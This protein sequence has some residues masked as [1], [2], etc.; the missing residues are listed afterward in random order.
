MTE[1]KNKSSVLQEIIDETMNSFR[2]LKRLKDGGES[3][4]ID[5]D[6]ETTRDRKAAITIKSILA[7][8]H[9]EHVG[10]RRLE[11]ANQAQDK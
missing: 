11:I 9:I 4:L 3:H 7:E 10:L 2:E 1:L 8:A 5:Y 6:Y